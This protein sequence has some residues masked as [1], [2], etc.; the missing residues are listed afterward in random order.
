MTTPPVAPASIP[1]SETA[2]PAV[3]APTQRIEMRGSLGAF[4]AVNVAAAVM[5][6]LM[7]AAMIGVRPGIGR[8]SFPL[9]YGLALL[10][11]AADTVYWLKRGVHVAALEGDTLHVYRGRELRHEQIPVAEITDVHLHQR[12]SRRSLQILLG[13]R[14]QRVPGFTYYPG[15][16]VWITSYAFD[17]REFD[18]FAQA[19]LRY[20]TD[21]G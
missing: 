4:A 13:D 15:R 10:Y 12:L 17:L 6:A 8:S 16:K 3:A 14:V 20:R 21:P 2:T 1:S 18:R 11:L 9:L 19:V 5:G 7:L